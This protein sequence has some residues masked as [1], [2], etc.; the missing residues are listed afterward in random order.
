[1]KFLF[2]AALPLVAAACAPLAPLDASSGLVSVADAASPVSTLQGGPAVI[3]QN[4][5]LQQPGNWT[6][7]N[8]AQAPVAE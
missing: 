4:R 8:D 2:A 6:R 5:S 7:L 1:M 3:Y